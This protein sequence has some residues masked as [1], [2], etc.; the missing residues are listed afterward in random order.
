MGGPR[1]TLSVTDAVA[2]IVGIVIGAGIFRTPSIVAAATNSKSTFLLVWP[3]GGAISLVGALCYA[4]L[5]SA[6]PSSGG[7]Y[8]Y[9]RLSFGKWVAFLF[10]WA[11]LTVIQTGSIVILA[12]VFGDYA[13][14]L[15][16][17]GPHASAIYAAG[18]IIVL[19]VVNSLGVKQ[20][21]RTQNL[22]T[23][24]KILGL[25]CVILVGILVPATSST[26]ATR[27]QPGGLRVTNPRVERFVRHPGEKFV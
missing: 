9:F 2:I 4:E 12:F 1:Q 27:G 13:A 8:H 25:V 21:T 17:L 14:Q 6:Y 20:G 11:R 7:D 24:A 18:S 10:A 5:A 15:V 16:P 3:L 22:L 23:G 19:T 26:T